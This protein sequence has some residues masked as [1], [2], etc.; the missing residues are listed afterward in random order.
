MMKYRIPLSTPNLSITN[1]EMQYIEEAF[2]MNWIAPLGPNVNAFESEVCAI[3]GAPF[4]VALTSG[5]AAIHM[6]LKAAEIKKK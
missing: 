4:S 3:A 2:E 5:T 6:A 1:K